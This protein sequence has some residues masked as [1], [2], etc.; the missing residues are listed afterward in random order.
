M[1]H[2]NSTLLICDL[3]N[4]L[5]DK[6]SVFEEAQKKMI[7][8]IKGSIPSDDDLKIL[9]K[10][11]SILIKKKKKH[12]YPFKILALSLWFYF[13]EELPINE[14]VQKSL[15]TYA[16]KSAK[17]SKKMKNALTLADKAA[18]MHDEILQNTP[19]NLFDDVK[20]VLQTL[21]N[22]EVKMVL[23]TEGNELMQ[24]KTLKT[25]DLRG[26]FDD[27]VLCSEKNENCF[28]DIKNHWKNATIYV[29]GD[30]IERDIEPG[31]RIGAITIWKPGNFNP[32]TPGKGLKKPD[33]VVKDIRNVLSIIN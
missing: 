8:V 26:F 20:D 1:E 10:M 12:L 25:N 9:R 14:S 2:K 24:E 4:T 32:G 19:A 17:T 13:H 27:I 15:D 7:E 33:F 28:L 22:R 30:G 11:D 3:D 29:V 23:L 18:E 16:D 6:N 5:V 31:N 21:K